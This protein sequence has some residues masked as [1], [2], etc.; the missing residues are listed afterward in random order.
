M[1]IQTIPSVKS[2]LIIEDN[3]G[4]VRIIQEILQESDDCFYK[5]QNCGKLA[6]GI[7]ILKKEKFDAVLLDL[8]L[9]DSS[10]LETLRVLRENNDDIPVIVLT[11]LSNEKLGLS[12]IK[13]GAQDFLIK[14]QM[15]INLL[16]KVIKFA[17]ERKK[18][19]SELIETETMFDAV[20]EQAAVGMAHLSME[21]KIIRINQKC[22]DILGY[23]KE[24]MLGKHVDLFGHKEDIN[25]DR[26]QMNKLL[27]GEIQYFDFEKRVVKK[28]GSIIWVNIT[29]S[30]IR[31][32]GKDPIM[33]SVVE[34][35][36]I[37][38]RTENIINQAFNNYKAL[39]ENSPEIIIRL[40]KN[41]NY[42]YA[43]PSIRKF[44]NITP[45]E[46][47]GRNLF[48]FTGQGRNELWLKRF[49][50]AA[51]SKKRQYYQDVF[52]STDGDRTIETIIIPD[53]DE[54]NNVNSYL[55]ISRDI[56]ERIQ[57][58][59]EIKRKN[60]LL[61]KILEN[62][63]AG[64]WII[65]KDGNLMMHNKESEI[66]WGGIENISIRKEPGFKG[67]WTE[68]G[69]RIEDDDW[70]C[71]RAYTYGE[72]HLNDIID[73]ECS[74]GTKKTIINSAVPM[75]DNKNNITG[76][77][78]INQDISKIMEIENKLK[79][80]LREKEMLMKEIHH[81]V[82]NNFQIIT[83]LLNLQKNSL[84]DK[85][86]EDV[87][88]ESQNRVRSMAILHEKLYKSQN[89]NNINF[90]VYLEDL[91][92]S[93]QNSYRTKERRI[94]FKKDIKE[95]IVSIDNA[96]SLGLIINELI[97]NSIKHAFIGIDEG[98]I[99]IS[100]NEFGENKLRLIV[101]DNGAGIPENIDINN[102][103]SL[104]MMLTN[105][106][107]AQIKG[108]IEL[109]RENGTEFRI[110]FPVEINKKSLP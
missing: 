72:T 85:S 100:L 81:R 6:E 82:K 83:S 90:G 10:D 56:T 79:I 61:E 101:K 19:E 11:I 66:I 3:L 13:N 63:P 41:L 54:N 91:L 16:D 30:L 59:E 49:N 17:I 75:T 2:I 92:K 87:L 69:K 103:D 20:F 106:F 58:Q 48:D 97:V 98:T 40:D 8:G 51:T 45:D 93:L 29:R 55:S 47:I 70:T 74:D 34:D 42:I 1:D 60:I 38:K 46:V 36:N 84:K 14:E 15:E 9:P 24:E 4:D 25:S 68:T 12:A 44:K 43:N 52:E 96:I 104:G 28:D 78:V 109:I 21:R 110:T 37:K 107:V 73:I 39:A 88:L 76:V 108:T 35:I 62:I 26:V 89:L 5:T 99:T 102:T 57:S 7:K 94:F 80:S 50:K 18:L 95:V 27:R 67:W 32:Y 33:F 22:C 31:P 105:S 86:I 65:G 71:Y 53:V 23:E 64:V 77:V